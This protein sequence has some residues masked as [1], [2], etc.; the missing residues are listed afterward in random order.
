[1]ITTKL[2]ISIFQWNQFYFLESVCAVIERVMTSWISRKI[3]QQVLDSQKQNY[4]IL[5]IYSGW[6]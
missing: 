2:Y 6:W 3:E 5:Y 4:T 1:M